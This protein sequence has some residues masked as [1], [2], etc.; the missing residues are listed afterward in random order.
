MAAT[1]TSPA[2]DEPVKRTATKTP[3]KR[4]AAKA[5]NG[6]AP[7]KRATKTEAPGTHPADDTDGG[8]PKKARTRAKAAGKAPSGRGTK[9]ASKGAGDDDNVEG[10]DENAAEELDTE[11]DL[12]GEPG[13]DI[14]I[15]SDLS[16][17]DLEDDVASDGDGDDDA[18]DSDGDDEAEDTASAA[19]PAAK[20]A[21]AEE[22][23]EIAEPSEKDK[24]SGDFVW[25]EDESE[26]LRQARKDAELTASADSVRAYLKQIGKVALLNAE[27]EV[28]LAKRIEAGLYG[29]QLMAEHAE[30][31]DKLPAAQRRDMMWICRD[32]DRAKN[33]LLEA[34]LRLVV[35][36][37][38]RYTGRGMA[39]L[40]LIQEGNLGLIRAVEKFDYTKGY[41]FST[42]ATWWI[43]QAITRA[44]AD[45][46]RTIRIPV[47]MVEVINKLGRIQRELLQDLGREPTPEELAKEMDITPE[48][49]LEIQQYARE[50]ISL[51]QTIGDEGDSQLGDFIED[52][53]AVVAV[54]AVSFTLLQ[55]QLQSVL[56]TLSEREAG[57]VRL[58]FGLTDGQPRTLD[59]IGQ[60][61]G[62]TRE[63]IR[64]I[65]S[66]TM[67]KLR[68]PSRSQVLRDYLD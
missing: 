63:R 2:T 56:E 26:A 57:V 45:Q 58:R 9:A 6:T 18:G 11:P 67:S 22:E 27:E 50:P 43:R 8:A 40:D 10:V 19:K 17:D 42:Y 20:K 38:K 62:V 28:E 46:A 64:Q 65:E 25:D 52:S 32:G 15:D 33:H 34:N 3:A 16:L 61:Y 12:E 55:D 24:A 54:D 49:V 51:D 44:M 29:T 35:S 48:K 23:A 37:A 13:E 36:L 21:P 1:K 5:A 7:A 39:F 31:G 68:H 41:K 47:H 60:V 14:D 4:P 66:K 53:E 59:E 30:R